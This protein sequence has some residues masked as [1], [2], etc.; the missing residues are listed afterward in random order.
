M[1]CLLWQT[2]VPLEPEAE[3]V[4]PSLQLSLSGFSFTVTQDSLLQCEKHTKQCHLQYVLLFYCMFTHSGCRL[5][6]VLITR[7]AISISM[8][9]PLATTELC[10]AK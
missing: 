7:E 8:L 6:Y 3:K 1:P 4:F 9:A 10:S 5:P 2:E